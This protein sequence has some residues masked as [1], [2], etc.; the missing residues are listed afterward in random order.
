MEW[1]GILLGRSRSP[2]ILFEVRLQ[3]LNIT[4]GWFWNDERVAIHINFDFADYLAWFSGSDV[5]AVVE[6]EFLSAVSRHS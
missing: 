2:N 6:F 1:E 4:R 3:I 5:D